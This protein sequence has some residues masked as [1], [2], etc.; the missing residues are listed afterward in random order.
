MKGRKTGGRKI[1]T[2][3]KQNRQLAALTADG[4][5]PLDFGLRIM[6]DAEQPIEVRILGA[7]LAA[8]YVHARPG[9]QGETVNLELPAV[10]TIDGTSQA[11]SSVVRS[12]AEGKITQDD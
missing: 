8:P 3:N 11:I 6:R 12:V 5:T 1:G 9:P 2:P 4:E 10:N 7:R